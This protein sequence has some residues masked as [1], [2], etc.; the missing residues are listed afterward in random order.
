MPQS[1]HTTPRAHRSVTTRRTPASAPTTC[2]SSEPGRRRTRPDRGWSSE[3]RGW[4]QRSSRRYR[5]CWEPARGRRQ[6]LPPVLRPQLLLLPQVWRAHLRPWQRLRRRPDPGPRP[7]WLRVFS[8][9][10]SL[11]VNQIAAVPVS[12]VRMR[13]TCSRLVTKILPSPI[14]PVR[15]EFSMASIT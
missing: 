3:S 6:A 15:A 7:A 13:T 2:S 14:L 11:S 1:S 12:P 10:V 9:C 8:W 4:W 5:L